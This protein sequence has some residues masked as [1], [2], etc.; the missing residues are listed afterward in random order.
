MAYGVLARPLKYNVVTVYGRERPAGPP[1]RWFLLS[2]TDQ[3]FV[4]WDPCVPIVRW[5]P[6]REVNRADVDGVQSLFVKP[7]PRP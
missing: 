2:S 5:F 7:G 1:P 3:E 4:V 6:K